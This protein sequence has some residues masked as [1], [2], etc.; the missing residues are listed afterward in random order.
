MRDKYGVQYERSVIIE[1]PHYTKQK[2]L[3]WKLRKEAR[4]EDKA[5][6][7]RRKHW[8]MRNR[9]ELLVTL[10]KNE[11]RIPGGI[12]LQLGTAEVGRWVIYRRAAAVT[13]RLD[14]FPDAIIETSLEEAVGEFATTT[15]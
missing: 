10:H 1:S 13:G 2:R 15:R 9:S 5:A 6:D 7:E 14:A 3:T 12:R 11:G 8:D 4:E